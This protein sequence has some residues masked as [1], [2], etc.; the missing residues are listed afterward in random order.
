MSA[1]PLQIEERLGFLTHLIDVEIQEIKLYKLSVGYSDF[2][3]QY[4]V[5]AD[6]KVLIV[7]HT[8]SI[9]DSMSE[10]YKEQLKLYFASDEALMQYVLGRIMYDITLSLREMQRKH[11]SSNI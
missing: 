1:I 7:I 4:G 9:L 2:V 5:D 8:N 10:K 3:R 11:N 6:L